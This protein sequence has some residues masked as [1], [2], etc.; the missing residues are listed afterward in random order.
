MDLPSHMI[1]FTRVVD[2]GSFSAAARTLHQS[3]SAISRQIAQLEDRVGVRLVT[4]GQ[5]GISLTE[6]GRAFHERCKIVAADIAET[7]DLLSS[8]GAEPRGTLR[9]VLTVAFGKAQILPILPE[10]L[11]NLPDLRISLELTDRPID[12]ATEDVDVAVRFSEQIDDP[13]AISRKLATNR[14]VICAAPSYL[15]RHGLPDTAADL[16]T[17]NCLRL[18][19][20]TRWN[21]W[22]LGNGN[23]ALAVDGN[24]EAN[25]A[26]AVYHAALAGLGIARLSTYLVSRDIRSGR[27]VRILPDYE[28]DDSSIV[29]IYADRRNL[30]QKTRRF[31]DFLVERFEGEPP[32]ERDNA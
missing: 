20:A 15:E 5:H 13:N 12:L 26:D 4:R 8:L 24:F 10:F 32:W 3:P 29:A 28:Q 6:E 16:G 18:T 22:D 27:L 19:T 31:I 23:A 2:T 11:E 7:E 21:E 17:H 14:R 1:L 25:S 9:V 30:A